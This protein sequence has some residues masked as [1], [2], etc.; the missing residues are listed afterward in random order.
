MVLEPFFSP[1][2]ERCL[3]KSSFNSWAFV[4]SQALNLGVFLDFLECT[5]VHLSACVI[6]WPLFACVGLEGNDCGF[7]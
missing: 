7:L 1:T 4:F 3:R 2:F 5:M 6:V